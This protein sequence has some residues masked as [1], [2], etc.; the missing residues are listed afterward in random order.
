VDELRGLVSSLTPR[1]EEGHLPW[2]ARPRVLAVV[3]LSLVL[4]LNLVFF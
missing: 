1:V 4:A 2:Y 3:V